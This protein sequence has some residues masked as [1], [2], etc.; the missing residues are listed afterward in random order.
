M[1]L[2]ASHD[3][4]YPVASIMSINPTLPGLD[5]IMPIV[6]DLAARFVERGFH[7]YL[8][9]GV[10]R[11]L[12]LG[13]LSV[14]DDIDL[15]TDADPNVIKELV[16]PMATALWTQGE[17]FGTIGAAINDRQ[18]EIT[19]HRAE[20]Y[21]PGSR[22]PVVAFGTSIIDDLERRDFTIN[23]MAVSIPGGELIDPFEGRQHLADRVL[24]TPLS[25]LEAF[26]DDPLRM[27]RA[28]RFIPR[29][30]LTPEPGL[31]GAA[32]QLAERLSIVSVERIQHELERLLN[33]PRAAEGLYFMHRC[34][35]LVGVLPA[36]ASDPVALETAVE[37]A[38]GPGSALVRRAALVAPLGLDDGRGSLRRLRYSRAIMAETS[39]LLAALPRVVEPDP[40][41]ERV[42]RVVRDV[43]PANLNDLRRL[44]TNT[45]G[46]GDAFFRCFDELV[47]AEDLDDFSV[48]VSGRE[49]MK[50]LGL[51]SGPEVG[52]AT[53]YLH[54]RRM[55]RGPLSRSEALAALTEWQTDGPGS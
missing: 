16:T 50:H 37:W 31:E 11:D 14:G 33:L 30:G 17:R 45:G 28:A 10:V 6:A 3:A 41:A 46:A 54:E 7:L 29:F 15:T 12:A 44:T 18:L 38:A 42:R 13:S 5:A 9:G 2:V 27:L 4:G 32:S 26:G 8:V 55:M 51:E 52:E 35:L 23:A 21:D 40:D 53:H 19:T 43:S 24:M 20:A 47:A 49:I 1:W 48:P 36:Y 39:R 22:K 25:P 34:H